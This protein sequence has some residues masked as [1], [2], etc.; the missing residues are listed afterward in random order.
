M[1]CRRRRR[2][3]RRPFHPLALLY[4]PPSPTRAVGFAMSTI[5]LA[6]A[7]AI[8]TNVFFLLPSVVLWRHTQFQ[9]EFFWYPLLALVSSM[10][11]SCDSVTMRIWSCNDNRSAMSFIDVFMAIGGAIC[12]VTPHLYYMVPTWV[13]PFRLAMFVLLFILLVVDVHANWPIG[14]IV[15]LLVT[16]LLVARRHNPSPHP[17]LFSCTPGVVLSIIGITLYFVASRQDN[18]VL[19]LMLH[20]AWHIP[21]GM[22]AFMFFAKLECDHAVVAPTHTTHKHIDDWLDHVLTIELERSKN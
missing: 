5:V 6:Q 22:A 13:S 17:T 12:V 10:H 7:W 1:S 3:H 2:R 14:I 20:G 8:G 11:H 9:F 21:M 15:L 16:I 4:L 18:T 19:R